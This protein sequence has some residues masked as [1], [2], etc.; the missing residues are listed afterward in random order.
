MRTIRRKEVTVRTGLSS[1]Q[2]DRLEAA[3]KFPRRV[4]LSDHVVAWVE[5][6]VSDWLQ[7]KVSERDTNKAAQSQVA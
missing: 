7:A 6:E 3:K 5:Q 4:R 1:S 2:I